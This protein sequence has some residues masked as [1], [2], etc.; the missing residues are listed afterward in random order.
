[1]SDWNG[2]NAKCTSRAHVTSINR[3]TVPK[4]GLKAWGGIAPPEI[5]NTMQ[6][7]CHKELFLEWWWLCTFREF[8]HFKIGSARRICWQMRKKPIR[9]P[10]SHRGES[11]I[12]WCFAEPSKVSRGL[13]DQRESRCR[14]RRAM[15]WDRG[16]RSPCCWPIVAV[17]VG[18]HCVWSFDPHALLPCW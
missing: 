3:P 5:P 16:W 18:S 10:C 13:H 11:K 8:Q 9:S 14:W 1:M 2:S 15:E 7:R 6:C 12:A 4:N 17:V